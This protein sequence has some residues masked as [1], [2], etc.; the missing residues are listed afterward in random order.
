ML[1]KVCSVKC[2]CCKKKTSITFGLES[3]WTSRFTCG[4]CGAVNVIECYNTYTT[5]SLALVAMYTISVST[6]QYHWK[7]VKD[8]SGDGEGA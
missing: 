7:I 3:D 6:L 8:I 1:E 4:E 5:T 2:A